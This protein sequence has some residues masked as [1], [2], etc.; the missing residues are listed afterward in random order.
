MK[1]SIQHI[2][3]RDI[4]PNRYRHIDRYRISDV[5]VEALIQSYDNSGF[6]DG[7]I[8]ARPHPTKDGKYEIAFGHHRIE[9]A[10]RARL[11]TVGLV[12]GP[13]TDADMLRMMADEN[14]EEFKGDH[15][16]AIETIAATIEAFGKGEIELPAVDPKHPGGQAVTLPAGKVYSLATVARFLGWIKPSDQQATNACRL[17]FDAYHERANIV[18]AL[19]GLAEEDRT[20]QSTEAVLR[21]TKA[22]RTMAT[23]A[24]KSDREVDA[25]AKRASEA[26]VKQIKKGAIASKVRDEATRIGR[27]AAR[28]ERSAP[29]IAAF[30]RTRAAGLKQRVINLRDEVDGILND[31][32]P[33]HHQ[34]DDATQQVLVN[35]LTFA[36][37]CLDGLFDKWVSRFTRRMSRDVTPK[38]RALKG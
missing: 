16:V 35:E 8:Q 22:A 29:E 19:Q 34:L 23:R 32:W 18:P 12:V 3:V 36:H 15:L 9:A 6:W 17:A 13:R 31:V 20:R 28:V 38:R 24:G 4:V 30:V 7:S 26:A 33:Y 14:R 2:A 1:V 27:E 5:K 21:A 10:K 37:K 25:A 11:E